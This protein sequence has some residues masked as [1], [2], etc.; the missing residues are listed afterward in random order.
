MQARGFV[1]FQ[2][3][4]YCLFVKQSQTEPFLAHSHNKT[5]TCSE[6]FADPQLMQKALYAY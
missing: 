3:A 6:S 4:K 2:G 1:F 5:L